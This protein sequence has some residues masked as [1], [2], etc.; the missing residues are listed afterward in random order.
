MKVFKGLLVVALAFVVFLPQQVQAKK[1]KKW[2]QKTTAW[3]EANDWV[4][5]VGQATY[6]HTTTDEFLASQK[7]ATLVAIEN[8]K[9]YLKVTKI[10]GFQIIDFEYSS[11]TYYVLAGAPKKK[12]TVKVYIPPGVPVHLPPENPHSH[13]QPEESSRVETALISQGLKTYATIPG[14]WWENYSANNPEKNTFIVNHWI[15]AIGMGK[16]NPKLHGDTGQTAA[17]KVAQRNMVAI[18]S[19]VYQFTSS[20]GNYKVRVKGVVKGAEVV[21]TK[22]FKGSNPMIMVLIRTPLKDF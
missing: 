14:N 6:K 8:L 5:A 11:D 3:E 16:P 2:T 7:K 20:P 18:V 13:N 4:Y 19:A 22:K 9:T 1:L 15:Y 21:K 12:N 10:K 17:I